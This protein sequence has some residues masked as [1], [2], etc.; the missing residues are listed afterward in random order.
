MDKTRVGDIITTGYNIGVVFEITGESWSK[1]SPTKG[2]L[3]VLASTKEGIPSRMLFG[4]GMRYY[5][6]TIHNYPDE[7]ERIEV[8][9]HIDPETLSPYM[10]ER[11]EEAEHDKTTFKLEKYISKRVCFKGR[12]KTERPTCPT[13]GEDLKRSYEA[14]KQD[15]GK[16][17][18]IPYGHHCKECKY[19]TFD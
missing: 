14:I 10:K 16:W 2:S 8:I 5:S 18:K 4:T 6:F 13:C 17:V 3:H 11:F 9:G 7:M 1:Y 15:S 12:G 19:Q